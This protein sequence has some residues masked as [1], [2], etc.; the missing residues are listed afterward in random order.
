[1]KK[2]QKYFA[3]IISG[4]GSVEQNNVVCANAAVAIQTVEKSSYDE[5]LAKAQESLISGK[6]LEKIKTIN[7]KLNN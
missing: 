3:S 2:Q 6:A 5:A 4:N 7:R 1:M